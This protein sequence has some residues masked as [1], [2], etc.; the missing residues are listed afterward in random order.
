MGLMTL[1]DLIVAYHVLLELAEAY[2]FA[3][4]ARDLIESR[5]LVESEMRSMGWEDDS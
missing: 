4:E 5:R 2:G 1:E 3:R